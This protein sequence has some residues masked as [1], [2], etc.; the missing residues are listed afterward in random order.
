M[1]ELRHEL[2]ASFAGADPFTAIL[3]LEGAVYRQ[4]DG[5][6]TLRFERGGRGYFAKIYRGVGWGEIIKNLV[7]FRLPVID[8]TTELRAIR[9]LEQLGVERVVAGPLL[10]GSGWVDCAHGRMPVPV[11]AVADTAPVAIGSASALRRCPKQN[12]PPDASHA[13]GT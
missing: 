4:M 6:R 3:D 11:P 13:Y 9:R 1:L 5:R 10:P 7:S 2:A 8:A 12:R